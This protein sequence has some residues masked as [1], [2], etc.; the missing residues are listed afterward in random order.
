MNH[1]LILT[2]VIALIVVMLV[3][4]G[5]TAPK[6]E[7]CPTTSPQSCPTTEAQSCP[8]SAPLSCPTTAA[9]AVPEMSAW[10]LGFTGNIP[11]N[12]IITFEPG[13]K[14]S[15]EVINP[16]GFSYFN[17]LW[18]QLSYDIVVNDQTYQ[19]YVVWVY[20][21]DPGT[22]QAE[23]DAPTPDPSLGEPPSW[24]NIIAGD[25][26]YPMTR[27]FHTSAIDITEGPLYFSC[28]A[29]GPDKIKIIGD[30]GPLNV[31]TK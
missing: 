22:T 19:N 25:V 28:L 1:K 31:P 9:Q 10:R 13:D 15:M 12:V 17:P 8:T 29:Q 11:I 14:C 3:V 21:A 6:A 2:R 30:L 18:N 23:M 7:A 4:A 24:M 5:C 26:I 27:T 20:S 16:V